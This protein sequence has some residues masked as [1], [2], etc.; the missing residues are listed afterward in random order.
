MNNKTEIFLECRALL[1][2]IAYN[3]LSRVDAAEDIVQDT[4]IKWFETETNEVRY[5]KALLLTN[6]LSKANF[7]FFWMSTILKQHLLL[8]TF[9]LFPVDIRNN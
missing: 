1:F 7:Y 9:Y 6:R 8:M 3:M 4:F 2:S 5:A